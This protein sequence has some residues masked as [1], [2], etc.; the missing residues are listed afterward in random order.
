MTMRTTKPNGTQSQRISGRSANPTRGEKE[1]GRKELQS[2]GGPSGRIAKGRF[3]PALLEKFR[4]FAWASSIMIEGCRDQGTLGN[5]L[6]AYG[7]I[8]SQCLRRWMADDELFHRAFL[9]LANW[10]CNSIPRSRPPLSELTG[11]FR[12]AE[13]KRQNDTQCDKVGNQ[14]IVSS[15]LL[16]GQPIKETTLKPP[17]RLSQMKR[18]SGTPDKT[19]TSQRSPSTQASSKTRGKAKKQT[20]SSRKYGRKDSPAKR[21]ARNTKTETSKLEEKRSSLDYHSRSSTHRTERHA[22]RRSRSLARSLFRRPSTPE[23]H[24]KI[25]PRQ[26]HHSD[27]STRR[28]SR[29]RDRDASRRDRVRTPAER[30]TR[31]RNRRDMYYDQPQRRRR[32]DHRNSHSL[33]PSSPTISQSSRT[34]RNS[35][36]MDNQVQTSLILKLLEKTLDRLEPRQTTTQN[37]SSNEVKATKED[38]ALSPTLLKDNRINFQ[39]WL[40]APQS[41]GSINMKK[42]FKAI[43]Y[44]VDV[45]REDLPPAVAGILALRVLR[46]APDLSQMLRCIDWFLRVFEVGLRF[47]KG[48]QLLEYIRRAMELRRSSAG[49]WEDHDVWRAVDDHIMV[50]KN[51][52]VKLEKQHHRSRAIDIRSVSQSTS[53][54]SDSSSSESTSWRR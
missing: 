24:G 40:T 11:Q 29:S 28:R 39:Q 20:K 1:D 46:Q 10:E 12:A 25:R 47:D 32:S 51:S 21:R 41:S 23:R 17:P 26:T 37:S 49:S 53:D 27:R 43:G 44:N 16:S 35:G 22:H 30:D 13:K 3:D 52:K 7:Q 15:R 31:S 2:Y 9:A 5:I 45:T 38:T 6:L 50:A 34:S 14:M 33:R 42:I 54:T 4:R 8:D 36:G 48:N 18:T 19:T